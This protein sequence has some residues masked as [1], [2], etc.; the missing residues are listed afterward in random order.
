M[1]YA[2][3]EIL[4]SIEDNVDR[5]L[6]DAAYRTEIKT[7]LTDL[8]KLYEEPEYIQD[9]IE[10]LLQATNRDYLMEAIKAVEM[11]VDVNTPIMFNQTWYTDR[12]DAVGYTVPAGGHCFGM[13]NMAKQ[14]FLANDLVTFR[15]RLHLINTTPIEDF[16]DEFAGLKKLEYSFR[17]KGNINDADRMKQTI[18]DLRAFFDGIVLYQTPTN[19]NELFDSKISVQ[20][21][22][23]VLPIVIPIELEKEG[24][25]P[26]KIKSIV[27]A[28]SHDELQCY[29]TKLQ[30]HL[31]TNSFALQLDSANHAINLNYDATTKHWILIDPNYLPGQEYIHPKLLA[32]T[33]FKAY[34]KSDTIIMHS[35]IHTTQDQSTAMRLGC[36]ELEKDLDWKQLHRMS[37]DNLNRVDATGKNQLMCQIGYQDMDWIKTALEQ[38]PDLSQQL[39]HNGKSMTALSLSIP[40]SVN[41]NNP[42]LIHLL[43]DH[44]AS[45]NPLQAQML[46][47]FFQDDVDLLSKALSRAC[48]QGDINVVTYLI[49]ENVPPTTEMLSDACNLEH[50]NVIDFLINTSGLKPSPELLDQACSMGN[51]DIAK[52]LAKAIMPQQIETFDPGLKAETFGATLKEMMQVELNKINKESTYDSIVTS[53]HKQSEELWAIKFVIYLIEHKVLN[54]QISGLASKRLNEYIAGKMTHDPAKMFDKKNID[55]TKTVSL[56]GINLENE[57]VKKIIT[58]LATIGL[59]FTAPSNSPT[60]VQQSMSPI[61][62]IENCREIMSKFKDIESNIRKEAIAN[63]NEK[64]TP[65]EPFENNESKNNLS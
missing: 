13:S 5:M 17:D 31:G 25:Q 19:Y 12:M 40:E 22:Q 32:S 29:L 45:I 7:Q 58:H 20:D 8:S 54:N 33:L 47:T 30:E 27:G 9:A 11:A 4:K 34:A 23:R 49:Q 42:E 3:T 50:I 10:E 38:A 46:L 15:Q 61:Q 64:I 21:A 60:T 43:L 18:V 51:I 24:M 14:A 39:V 26:E 57:S 62:P 65:M 44:G 63:E 28:Y 53:F 48:H 2:Y 56:Q 35:D 16:N 1:G 6:A 41:K 55:T 37:S 36:A 52:I 59:S